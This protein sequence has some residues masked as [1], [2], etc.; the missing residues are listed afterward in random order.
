[1]EV[2]QL[3]DFV[4]VAHTGSFSQAALKC[5]VAQPS[6]SKAVQRLEAEVGEK[7]L[8]RSKRRTVLTPAGEMAFHRAVRILNEVD[9]MKRELAEGRN[10][11]RGVVNVGVL[12]T[13]APYLLPAVV[14]RFTDACPSQ[15]II[16]HEDTTV[17]LLR[18]IE[19][20]ELDLG[21]MIL[22]IANRGFQKETLFTDELLLAVSSNHPLAVKE[23]ICLS[24][25]PK[26]QFLLMKEGH[27]LGDQ[28]ISFCT[29]NALRLRGFLRSSQI[30]TIQSFVLSGLG[31]SFVPEMVKLD[32]RTPLVYRSLEKPKPTRTV[33]VVSRKG[34]EHTQATREFL[35]QL[36][37]TVHRQPT[38][39]P[40]SSAPTSKSPASR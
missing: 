7:L 28:I 4:T 40:S 10:S 37:L 9:A 21:I 31:A 2:H 35:K 24:D 18:M 34:R 33:I 32:G 6:L 5:C 25:L 27:C 30:D 16:V 23:K 29:K 19:M 38:V 1:M 26:E 20:C 22:P 13:I 3:R 39:S 8:V 12:P 14:R 15:D 17:N 11:K 36:R